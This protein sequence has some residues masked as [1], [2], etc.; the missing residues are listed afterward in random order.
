MTHSILPAGA[1]VLPCGVTISKLLPSYD[2]A[3]L[4]LHETAFGPGRFARTAFRLR[5]RAA[6]LSDLS[7]VAEEE[8]DLI[9]AVSLSRIAV[10]DTPG[11]LLGPL[12]VL[13]A[14]RHLGV[15]KALLARS[16]M[17]AFAAGEPYVL[18]VGD[19]PY[20]APTGFAVVPFGSMA[21]PG[22][23]DPARLLI[24]LNPA[25]TDLPRGEVRGLKS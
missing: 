5:E 14:K 19:L 25:C 7:L 12:A 17:A 6:P 15:G 9:G 4:A 20:Y 3:V 16:V 8:G 18:L 13:P 24:A 2:D 10:G 22:P 11:V 21:M 23:V 1:P